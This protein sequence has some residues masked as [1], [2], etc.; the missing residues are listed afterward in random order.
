M[1]SF[2]L[3]VLSRETTGKEAAGR[4]RR[5]GQVPC[6]IYGHGEEPKKLS[7]NAKEMRDLI[8]H[9]HS[10]GLL[11]LK[12][13]GSASMP[14][15][16]KSI[17]RHPATRALTTIDFLNVSLRETV[18]ASV[19]LVLEGEPVGVR[20][21]GGVLVHAL[22]EL[23][24]EALPQDLPE[25]ITID[26]SNLEFNGAPIHVKE[27]AMPQGVTA[28]TDG[29]EPVAVVNAPDVEPI[30]EETMT[31]EQIEEAEGEG[32]NP[33]RNSEEGKE[34]VTTGNKSDTGEKPGKDKD[35]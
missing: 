19:P 13:E 20:V 17:Q 25:H 3:N 22:H 16:I 23:L 32:V 30:V 15:I 18:Q 28:I 31:A 4:M 35:K 27:I 8:S 12:I 14:A 6:V 26:V 9:G 33:M 29:E 34:D 5:A 10:H 1:S 21:D 7:V 24:I 2:D 11:N